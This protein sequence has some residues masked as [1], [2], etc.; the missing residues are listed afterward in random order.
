MPLDR[1]DRQL[2][3]LVQEDAS[4]TAERLAEQVFLSPSAVQRRLRRL[5][6]Q[7]VIVRDAA[8]V[9]PKKVGRPT[10]FVVSLQVERERPELLAQ[11]RQWLSAQ[12]HVQQA[13][14]VTGEADFVLVITAPDTETYD[15]LMAR[16]VGDNPNVKRFTTNVAL[17]VVKRG[18]TIPIP[19]DEDE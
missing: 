10:F 17:G 13:F 7:G 9:D 12:E 19:L 16:L 8:V 5:R 11:L 6:E 2:L 3:N 18:L 15:A 14:Y 4:Q 1:F